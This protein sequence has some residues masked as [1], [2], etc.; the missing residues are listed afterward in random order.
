MYNGTHTEFIT[1]AGL[2]VLESPS[3]GRCHAMSYAGIAPDHQG[4][5]GEGGVS[6]QND[7]SL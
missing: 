4:H 3:Y 2:Y 5:G 7:Y 6:R 1:D